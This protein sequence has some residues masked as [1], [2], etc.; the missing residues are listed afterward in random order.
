MA[1]KFVEKTTE[2]LFE[3]ILFIDSFSDYPTQVNYANV[4]IFTNGDEVEYYA[5]ESEDQSESV[6]EESEVIQSD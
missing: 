6:E 1:N 5:E 4:K 2:D 3:L